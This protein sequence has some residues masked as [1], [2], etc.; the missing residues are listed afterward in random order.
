MNSRHKF[1]K[2][3]LLLFLMT[4]NVLA[5][6]FWLEARPFYT[7][8]D[9]IVDI[10]VHVGNEYVGETLPNIVNWYTDFS[11]YSSQSKT[12]I[13]GELGMDPA[14]YFTPRKA[15]TYAIG[16]QSVF[17]RVDLDAATFNQYLQEE[18]LDNAI[19]YRDK[20]GLSESNGKESYIRHAKLLVQAG[21]HFEVDNARVK[22]GYDLEI[23]PLSNPYRS[24]LNDE[25]EVRVLYKDQ[26]A[27]DI[28]LTA[29]SKK[30]PEKLQ[31]SRSNQ[32]GLVSIKLDSKGPWLLKAVKILR[33][34]DKKVDWRSHWASLTFSLPD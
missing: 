33:V 8:V 15:G 32:D 10:S 3:V 7:P 12:Q 9:K 21:D 20:H 28:L 14:G 34:K 23:I 5:H 13:E 18:G 30:H 1:S 22:F 29:F 27:N 31:Q 6:D 2:I 24:Q 17:H 4:G 25:L 26:P 19:S 11:L 16:Y